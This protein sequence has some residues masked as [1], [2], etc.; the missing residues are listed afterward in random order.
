K[1]TNEISKSTYSLYIQNCK[2]KIEY[3]CQVWWH[4]PIIP[5]TL[6]TEA[7]GSLT[8]RNSVPAWTTK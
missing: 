6:E 5:A 8:P 7:R 1:E 2:K 3:S 4:M